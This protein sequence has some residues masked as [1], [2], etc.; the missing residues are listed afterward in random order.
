MLSILPKATGRSVRNGIQTHVSE[1][2]VQ[3]WEIQ[4]ELP[5]TRLWSGFAYKIQRIKP[6]S[7]VSWAFCENQV[8][9]W[10]QWVLLSPFLSPTALY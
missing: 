9:F 4:H 5:G 3:V 6:L 10:M 7:P 1:S 2:T 8:V